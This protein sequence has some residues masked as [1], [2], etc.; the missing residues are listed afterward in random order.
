MNTRF[1]V[2]GCVVLMSAAMVSAQSGQTVRA[3]KPAG[4]SLRLTDLSPAVERVLEMTGTRA[5]LVTE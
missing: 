3:T 5:L 1:L 4:A 2:T